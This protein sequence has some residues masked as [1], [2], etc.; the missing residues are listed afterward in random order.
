MNDLSEIPEPITYG[1]FANP[2]FQKILREFGRSVFGRASACGEMEHFLRANKV[3]GTTCMEIGTYNGIT[4]ILLSQFFDKVISVSVDEDISRIR[5]HE[6]VKFLGIRN[7]RFFDVKDNPEKS[8]V[9]RAFKFD[10]GYADGDHSM[11][12]GTDWELLKHSGHVLFHEYWPLQPP[13]W[14]LVNSL[15]QH[16]VKRAQHDCFALWKKS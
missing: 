7:I 3:G 10:F 13:V 11:D 2:L 6:I 14:N 4:A 16:E 8:E 12:T 1:A 15:P 9:V 5:K